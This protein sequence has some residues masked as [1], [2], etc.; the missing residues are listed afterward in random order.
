MRLFPEALGRA[1]ARVRGLGGAAVLLIGIWVLGLVALAAVVEFGHRLD[2]ARRA[3]VVIARMQNQQSAVLAVAFAPAVA[4]TAD[5]PSPAL[6]AIRL[7]AAENALNGSLATLTS[8]GHSAEPARI[9][10]LISS[11]FGLVG[12]LSL[13]VNDNASRSAALEL[14]TGD[15]PSGAAGRLTTALTQADASYSTQAARSRKVA[16]VG[17][18]VSILF[19]LLAFSAAFS[20]TVAARKRSHHDASTDALTGLGNRRKLFADMTRRIGSLD[21]QH[22]RRGDL[23]P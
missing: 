7:N 9:R 17:A 18:V 4:A 13:L 23:R 15:Q 21:A 12:H 20:R 22:R 3:Q 2:G 5:I 11:Y 10:L 1:P 19:L 6:T 16:T 8:I 14:G